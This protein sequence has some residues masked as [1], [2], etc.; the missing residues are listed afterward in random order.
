MHSGLQNSETTSDVF[1]N[2]YQLST[3]TWM[4][5][6]NSL[7]G[8]LLC[9]LTWKFI[10]RDVLYL[11]SSAC[12]ARISVEFISHEPILHVKLPEAGKQYFIQT[13]IR[14]ELAQIKLN[15]ELLPDMVAYVRKSMSE[16]RVN[17][18]LL[19][20]F[21]SIGLL[22]TFLSFPCKGERL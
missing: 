21:L 2:K 10:W 14:N 13:R 17:A 6:Q 15:Q 8:P 7:S 18:Q 11:P 22:K 16:I 5:K 3:I 19:K 20:V 9:V 4:V 1:Q 12:Q